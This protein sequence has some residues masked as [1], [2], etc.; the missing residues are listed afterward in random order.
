[1]DKTD[2]Q[3]I[4]N[5]HPNLTDKLFARGFLFT[6]A[7]LD[8]NAY[9]FFGQW[10]KEDIHGYSL[11]V[12]MK[13]HYYVQESGGIDIVLIGHTYNPFSGVHDENQ[14]LQGLLKE[15]NANGISNPQCDF[16]KGINE[17]TGVFTIILVDKDDIYVIGDASGMQTTFYLTEGSASKVFISS[18]TNLIGDL[19]SLSW[20]PFI[21]ELVH[22]RFFKL[23]GNALPGNLTQFREVKRLIPNHYLKISK[24]NTEI[25]RFYWPVKQNKTEEQIADEVAELLHRN[26]ELISRK[27]KH[28]AIS[29]TGGCDSK[30]TLACTNGLY[31]RFLYFSYISSESEKVD[32][33]AAE[34][35]CHE[36]GLNHKTYL[37]AEND[38]ELADAEPVREILNWN[39]G[40][41][42]YS[43]PNDVRK[44]IF[45]ADTMDFDVEVKSWASEIGRAYYSK[46]FHERKVFGEC[47]TP[48]KCT[49]LYKFFLHNRGLVRKTDKIFEDYLKN[50]FQQAKENPVEWQEQFFWE[51]RVPS[52]NG[53]VI[54]GE[55]RY[56]FDITLPYNNRLILELLLSAPIETRIKDGIYSTIRK[57]MNPTIDATGIAV[58]N[59]KHTKNRERLEELYY[60]I[61]SHCKF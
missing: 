61:H 60:I 35:I 25:I 8:L 10:N 11:F 15:Y 17:L 40:N 46:R 12:S 30:T 34:K 49:T 47:P 3:L 29:M 37:I 32:A 16:W 59:L 42:R 51:F 36:L 43:H 45:F 13:Q 9:P 6:D 21:E 53:L 31:D 2:I 44:R 7:N 57:K 39:T 19:L 41:I 24:D 52:W 20:D 28:P 58:T 1:M 38:S 27:W 54:T 55:H 56:S 50:Y 23:L 18:H 14:I 26:M 33:V 4:L 5:K 22:Y 48:R